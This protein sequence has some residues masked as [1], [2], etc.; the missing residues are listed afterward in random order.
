MRE[1]YSNILSAEENGDEGGWFDLITDIQD[2]EFVT[3]NLNIRLGQ[4]PN[5]AYLWKR[6]ICFLQKINPL[7]CYFG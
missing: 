4:N 6:Y 7:V 5:S 3:S 2:E 1:H